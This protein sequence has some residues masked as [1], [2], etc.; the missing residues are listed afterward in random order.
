MEG[1][2]RHERQLGEVIDFPGVNKDTRGGF[3]AGLNEL[4]ISAEEKSVHQENSHSCSDISDISEK[5]E[6]FPMNSIFE[7]A[8]GNMPWNHGMGF[9]L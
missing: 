6:V 4:T 3:F 9:F 2:F 8:M 5:R 7:G 1:S